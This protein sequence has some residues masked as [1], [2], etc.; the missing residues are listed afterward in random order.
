MQAK[1]KTAHGIPCAAPHLGRRPLF[2]I[3]LGGLHVEAV[4]QPQSLL[5]RPGCIHVHERRAMRA[6][7]QLRRLAVH[8][9]QGGRQLGHPAGPAGEQVVHGCA[10]VP[11]RSLHPTSRAGEAGSTAGPPAAASPTNALTCLQQR[12]QQLTRCRPSARKPRWRMALWAAHAGGS[13]A[14]SLREATSSSTTACGR[15][16]CACSG[17]PNREHESCRSRTHLPAAHLE[18]GQS[19]HMPA[20][21]RR[22]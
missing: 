12:S 8:C 10:A 21:C 19:S 5:Q 7:G 4:Q 9:Q 13:A 11:L 18:L 16:K 6:Q 20:L 14:S 2:A 15:H 1:A 17:T 22:G 3:K